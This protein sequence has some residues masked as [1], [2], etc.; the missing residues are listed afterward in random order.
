MI[1]HLV[2]K[3]A[4]G[5]KAICPLKRVDTSAEKIVLGASEELEVLLEVMEVREIV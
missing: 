3:L 1:S 4:E 2:L 5:K